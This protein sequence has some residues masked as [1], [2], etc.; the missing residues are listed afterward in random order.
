MS[1]IPHFIRT[2][3]P[4]ASPAALGSKR[5]MAVTLVG[6]S[7][8]SSVDFKDAATDTGTVLFSL[9]TLAATTT[10]ICLEEVG[11]IAFSTDIFCKPAGTGAIVYAWTA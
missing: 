9:N 7:A 6:G 5:L 4:V 10:H 1:D 11:G 2:T 8:N 3:V